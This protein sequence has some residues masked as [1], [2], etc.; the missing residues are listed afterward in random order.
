MAGLY[1]RQW[2]SVLT[3]GTSKSTASLRSF[4]ALC[5]RLHEPWL[6]R[7]RCLLIAA[8]MQSTPA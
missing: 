8:V 1:R 7:E 3:N 4:V 6:P 2:N 5:P